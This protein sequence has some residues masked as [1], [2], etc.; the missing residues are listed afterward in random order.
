MSLDR[1]RSDNLLKYFLLLILS[2]IIHATYEKKQGLYD[3]SGK[4]NVILKKNPFLNKN[5][6]REKIISENRLYL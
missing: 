6:C 5:Y 1:L 3:K 2:Y 4:T